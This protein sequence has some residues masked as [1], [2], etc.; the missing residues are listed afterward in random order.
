[1]KGMPTRSFSTAL[2]CVFIS[3]SLGCSHAGF[4]RGALQEQLGTQ[5]PV[6]TDKDIAAALNKKA[7][8][9][10]PFKLA[11]YFKETPAPAYRGERESWRWTPADKSLLLDGVRGAGLKDSLAD[12]R[13]L[14]SGISRSDSL[15]DLRL[16]AAQQGSDALLVVSGA[17]QIDKYADGWAWSYALVAPMFFVKGSHADGLFISRAALWDVRNEFL[18]LTAEAEGESQFRYPLFFGPDDKE[19]TSEA[20]A[21]AVAELSREVA[22]MI[23]GEKR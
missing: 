14:P 8:L 17:S 16:A 11:V 18:Y 20:K 5:A 3:G 7:N 22:R 23:Q 15:K 9:P 19:V 4:N 10:R 6:T 12:L 2:I 1:M 13:L 21:K